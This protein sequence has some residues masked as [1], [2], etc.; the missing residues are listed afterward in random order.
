MPTQIV[1]LTH[2][3]VVREIDAIL[4]TYPY[5]PY[6]QAFANPDLRQ[7][8]ITYVLN[9]INNH[10]AAIDHGAKSTSDESQLNLS[11]EQL[12]QLETFIHQGI[13]KLYHHRL[14]WIK[15]HIP[16]VEQN[17][18]EPSHWFG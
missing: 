18:L 13:Q 3:A 8:L 11:R 6:R 14:M 12:K 15:G 5:H 1:N 10:Y 4:D 16:D 7:H 2:Y 9:R 17:Q